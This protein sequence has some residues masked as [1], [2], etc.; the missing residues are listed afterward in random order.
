M[1]VNADATKDPSLVNT[2]SFGRGWLVQIECA[3]VSPLEKLM[4][5]TT[6]DKKNAGPSSPA[7]PQRRRRPQRRSWSAASAAAIGRRA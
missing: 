2:D 4:D 3:D 6:Y 1:A 7:H 5:A